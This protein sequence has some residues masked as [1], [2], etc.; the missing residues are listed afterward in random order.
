MATPLTKSSDRIPG[1][2]KKAQVMAINELIEEEITLLI[3]RTTVTCFASHCPYEI[4]VGNFYDIELTLNLAEH[5]DIQK[6]YSTETS[7]ERTGNGFSYILHGILRDDSFETFTLL[8]DEGIHYD[9]PDLNGFFIKLSVER[10][11][12]AFL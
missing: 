2:I 1:N 10:I 11:D 3:D 8:S 5:Y 6:S 7:V 12:A 9:H 4:K